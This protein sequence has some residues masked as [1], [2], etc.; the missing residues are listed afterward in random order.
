MYKYIVHHKLMYLCIYIYTKVYGSFTQN[1]P[2]FGNCFLVFQ[3]Q[4]KSK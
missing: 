2:S 3:K 4:N 1:Y